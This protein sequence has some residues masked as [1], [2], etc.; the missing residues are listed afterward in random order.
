MW[1]RLQSNLY[2]NSTFLVKYFRND[3]AF[4]EVPFVEITNRLNP[5]NYVKALHHWMNILSIVEHFMK[6]RNSN[7]SS[8]ISASVLYLMTLQNKSMH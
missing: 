5:K 6:K 1:K 8:N 2:L 3:K 4:I 7:K